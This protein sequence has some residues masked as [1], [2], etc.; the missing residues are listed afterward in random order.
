[1]LWK[2]KVIGTTT[3]DG[4]DLLTESLG[5]LRQGCK[6][7]SQNVLFFNTQSK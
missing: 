2:D 1:M 7:W 4:P 5:S 6:S 3:M